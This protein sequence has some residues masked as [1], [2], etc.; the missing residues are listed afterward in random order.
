MYL[1]SDTYE[2]QLN[3]LIV[4]CLSILFEFEM[5]QMYQDLW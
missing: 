2:K 4:R 1:K 5:K 3:E